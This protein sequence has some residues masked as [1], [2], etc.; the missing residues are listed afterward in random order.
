M[1]KWVTESARVVAPIAVI[2]L[3]IAVFQVVGSP[4]ETKPREVA[5]EQPQPVE[6]VIVESA[7]TGITL[8]VDGLVVPFRDVVIG[9]DVTGRVTEKY[10]D[11]KAGAFVDA[12]TPLLKIDEAVYRIERDAAE[13]EWRRAEL[14]YKEALETELQNIEAV[15]QDAKRRLELAESERRRT[16]KLYREGIATKGSLDA[17]EQTVLEARTRLTDLANQRRLNE[18]KVA[19]LKFA[20]KIALAKYANAYKDWQRS[21]VRAPCC[22]VI[23]EDNVE[24]DGFV[25]RGAKLLV[26]EDTRRVEV[27]CS[28]TLDEMAWLWRDVRAADVVP[29][30]SD[31]PGAEATEGDAP[32]LKLPTP[33][34]ELVEGDGEEGDD[35][36]DVVEQYFAEQPFVDTDP[37][38]DAAYKLPPVPVVVSFSVAGRTYEWDGF[39]KRYDGLGVDER[40][41]TVPCRIE[42]PNPRKY[43][44]D[45]QPS[46]GTGPRA[47]L[48]GMFVQVQT[49]LRPKSELLRLPERAVR[50]GNEVWLVKEGSTL[51]VVPVEVVWREPGLVYVTADKSPLRSGDDVVVSPLPDARPGM[52]L[53]IESSSRI[54]ES[55]QTARAEGVKP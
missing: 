52:P 39:F 17:A 49:K 44:V 42:V 47:L 40:S 8:D 55:L 27:K 1:N 3:G 22:G 45:G 30:E 48:R 14:D 19:R 7:E 13:V 37:T 21:I 43:R 33:I 54:G 16:E 36:P 35:E 5:E 51:D 50:P 6:T 23:V 12:S 20:A 26:L 2:G 28:L 24:R 29:P 53:E 18:N 41:R 25:Q 46:D 15:E 9:A 4:P 11:W 38:D 10:G 32:P 34:A 31:S